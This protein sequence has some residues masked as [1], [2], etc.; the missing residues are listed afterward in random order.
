[1]CAHWHALGRPL[2][3]SQDGALNLGER[4]RWLRLILGNPHRINPARVELVR[5]VAAQLAD[6]RG[7]VSEHRRRRVPLPPIAVGQVDVYGR[8]FALRCDQPRQRNADL[9]DGK[10]GLLRQLGDEQMPAD[11]IE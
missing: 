10:T 11:V 1:M 5:W 6:L 2:I 3:V 7:D 9:T 8:G 4:P